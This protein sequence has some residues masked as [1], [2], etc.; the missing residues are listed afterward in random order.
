MRLL[1]LAALAAALSAP[2][3][4]HEGLAHDG[5]PAGQTYTAG[6]LT[7]TGA[8]TRAMLP[9]AQS[10][11]GYLTIENTGTIPDT[12]IGAATEAA[13]VVQLHEMKMEGDM[14]K[15]TERPEG[16]VIPAGETVALAPG[17]LHIMFLGVGTPFQ[18]GE[19]LE[20]VLEFAEAGTVPV[21]LEVGDPAAGG[22]MAMDHKM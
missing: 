4:A 18:E 2:A 7:I 21:M 3:I 14:M 6:D 1:T 8:F 17:G 20:V 16:I 9:N 11:G 22:P 5:C 15:M 12:L 19:C 10:A 13:R